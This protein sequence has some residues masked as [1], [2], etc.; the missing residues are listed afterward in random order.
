MKQVGLRFEVRSPN[1]DETPR[2]GESPRA[3]VSR[4]SRAKAESVARNL[5][6]SRRRI[7]IAA[8]TI[9]VAPGGKLILGKPSSAAEARRMLA[10]LSGKWH[11][12][13]T[14]YRLQPVNFDGKPIQ[15]VIISKVKMRK[16]SASEIAT[17][18][19][20]GEPMD[21]AGSYAAQGFGMALIESLEGSYTN[22]VGLPMCQLL[23]DLEKSF[24]VTTVFK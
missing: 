16:L 15:R 1:A 14:G 2:R 5:S 23:I 17:Y 20:S 8:D 12:V 9:V 22:V 10:L 13:L 19:A 4:L 24:G 6:G 3:L 21:K 7:V 11:S 18:V